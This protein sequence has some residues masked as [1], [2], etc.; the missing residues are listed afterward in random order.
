MRLLSTFCANSSG[1]SQHVLVM[2]LKAFASN[3]FQFP[4]V[5]LCSFPAQQFFPLISRINGHSSYLFVF[6]DFLNSW[7][8]CP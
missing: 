5:I 4:A 7:D 8:F 1:A 6:F 3:A 2:T